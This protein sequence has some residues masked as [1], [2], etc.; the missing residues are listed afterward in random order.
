VTRFSLLVPVTASVEPLSSLCASV[1][2]AVVATG[3]ALFA[4]GI[5]L[6]QQNF[7]VKAV[8]LVIATGAGS[9]PDGLARM[10]G[11]KLSER[12][13]W[14]VVI[15][16]RP[17]AGGV[18]AAAVVA[19]AAPDGHTLLYAL[20]N[21]A[22]A[23]ALQPKVPYDPFK[24]FAA[25]SHIGTGTNVLVAS[26]ALGAKTVSE[27]IALAK[28]QPGKLIYGAGGTGSAGHLTGV[29]FNLIAGIKAVQVTFKGGPEAAIEVLAGR[30]HYTVATMGVALPWVKEGKLVMLAV[31][32]PQRSPQL[33]DVPALAETF[34]DFKR[35]E[36]TTAL[37][38]P[39]G[40]PRPILVQISKDVARILDLPDIKERLQGMGYVTAPTTPEEFD[41]ILR[42][43]IATLSKV[44]RDAGLRPK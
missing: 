31:A 2:A 6:A 18:L 8:R 34:S 12:W 43:Q 3:V 33:P 32:T 30:S 17:G 27:F 44:V 24:D 29:R 38:A 1:V 36:N 25:I 28:A 15:D 23:T 20:P 7:P 22:I 5:A 4:P 13:G 37:L 11:Q 39:A 14:G 10:L 41:K 21:F 35:P 42:E 40:T 9:Q 26:P 19:K 16:N